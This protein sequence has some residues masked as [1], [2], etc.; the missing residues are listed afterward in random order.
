MS[1]RR[2][3]LPVAVAALMGAFLVLR[4]SAGPP[5]ASEAAALVSPFGVLVAYDATGERPRVLVSTSSGLRYDAL[6]RGGRSGGLWFRAS[7][8]LTGGWYRMPATDAPASAGVLITCA[9]APSDACS[10][11]EVVGEIKAADVVAIEIE[12]GGAVSRVAVSAPGYIVRLERCDRVP[13]SI[14]WLDQRGGVVWSQEGAI[15][16][17]G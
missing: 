14:R 5:S 8:Q 13:D 4:S 3:L 9:T 6:R 1:V 7:W 11:I 12:C 10:P 15:P 2:V 17:R 16:L